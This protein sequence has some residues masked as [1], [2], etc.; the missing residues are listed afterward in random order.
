[1]YTGTH[2]NP[3]LIS[4]E[5]SRLRVETIVKEMKD[6]YVIACF[7]RCW[8]AWGGQRTSFFFV[9]PATFISVTSYSFLC[10]GYMPSS[11]MIQLEALGRCVC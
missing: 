9:M 10:V 8:S 5:D 4:N 1:M 6:Q 2:E 7:E 11:D 3:E